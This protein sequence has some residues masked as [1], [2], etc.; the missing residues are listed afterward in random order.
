ML[1]CIGHD[2]LVEVTIEMRELTYVDFS[3]SN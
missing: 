1:A 3:I 2:L